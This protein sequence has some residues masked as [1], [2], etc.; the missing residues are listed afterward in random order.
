MKRT[1][2]I[3]IF[4]LIAS[5]KTTLA[6]ALGQRWGWPVIHSDLVRKTLAGISPTRR[7]ET[8]YGQGIYAAEF[9]GHTYQEMFRQAQERLQT[10]GSVILEGSFMRSVDRQQAR[11]LAAA[12]K[13]E[14]FFILCTCPVEE[15][16][17]R[18][19]RRA[20]DAQAIS[21]GRQ[22]I[23]VE[24]QKVFE[25]ITDLEETPVLILDTTRPL[26]EIAGETEDFL[27]LATE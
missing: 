6:K 3:V 14:V 16:L 22:E 2:L 13:A 17:R 5:G 18:L 4:G 24:Q 19:A 10:G 7:V 21:D 27:T 11:R 1:L 25:P 9:S 12:S 20:A 23:L 15:T 8:S 26:K